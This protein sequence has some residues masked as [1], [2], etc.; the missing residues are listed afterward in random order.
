MS[1]FEKAIEEQRAAEQQDLARARQIPSTYTNRVH[2]RVW[3]GHARLT[4]GERLIDLDSTSWSHS[5]TMT[6]AD[7]LAFADL[8]YDQYHQEIE[9]MEGHRSSGQKSQSEPSDDNG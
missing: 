1:D 4:F 5:V 9:L 8:I 7:A 2:V 6:T 3:G